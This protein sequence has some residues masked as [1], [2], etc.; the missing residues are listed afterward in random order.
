MVQCVLVINRFNQTSIVLLKTLLEIKQ[1][2][3]KMDVQIRCL[4]INGY[5]PTED[6]KRNLARLGV[7]IER[8][9][10]IVSAD[11]NVI[12]GVEEI[13]NLFR[14]N[15]RADKERK[16]AIAKNAYLHVPDEVEQYMQRQAH[17]D[18]QEDLQGE[19]QKMMARMSDAA[20]RRQESMK[21]SN[22]RQDARRNNFADESDD[23]EPP[24]PRGRA[25]GRGGRTQMPDSDDED[26]APQR[27]RGRARMDELPTNL[28][29]AT[30]DDALMRQY[31]ENHSGDGGFA[32]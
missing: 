25:R 26:D 29:G 24:R 4:P 6:D 11:G 12:V 21:D 23:D 27:G 32:P 30:G 10:T 17:G 13:V 2:I 14:R 19:Q 16:A 28:P 7:P 22:R 20:A 18:D 1:W 3:R 9:P 15:I 31:L 5:A 8:T